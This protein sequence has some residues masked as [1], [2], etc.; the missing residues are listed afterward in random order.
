[1]GQLAAGATQRAAGQSTS[2]DGF[3]W[4]QLDDESW[5]RDDVINALGDCRSIP[6]ME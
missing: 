5:V 1:M 6:D 4:W 2:D 3:V